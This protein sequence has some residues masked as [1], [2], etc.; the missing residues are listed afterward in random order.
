MNL[1]AVNCSFY[2]ET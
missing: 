2:K 1:I